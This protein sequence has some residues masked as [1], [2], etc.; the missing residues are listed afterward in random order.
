MDEM[1]PVMKK[2]KPPLSRPMPMNSSWNYQRWNSTKGLWKCWRT[3]CSNRTQLP[4]LPVPSYRYHMKC[5]LIDDSGFWSVISVLH[6]YSSSCTYALKKWPCFPDSSFILRICPI[7]PQQKH[8]PPFCCIFSFPLFSP[9]CGFPFI[10]KLQRK[11]FHRFLQLIV[12]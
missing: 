10:F 11:H 9:V 6:W 4:R 8:L 7:F 3:Y 2:S 5:L 12:W 1:M